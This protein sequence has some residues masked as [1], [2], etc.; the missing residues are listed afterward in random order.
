MLEGSNITESERDVDRDDE[1]TV[2]DADY[3]NAPQ[4][5]RDR[6]ASRERLVQKVMEK[7]AQGQTATPRKSSRSKSDRNLG[8]EYSS[9]SRQFDD[10]TISGAES[11]VL[12]SNTGAKSYRSGSDISNN[13][14]LLGMVEDTI[15]RIILPE[16]NALKEEKQDR[17][18]RSFESSRRPSLLEDMYNRKGLERSLSK[19]SSTPNISSKPRVVLNR[20]GEDPG[21]ILSRGDSERKKTRKSSR[22]S[23]SDE[24]PSSRHSSGRTSSRGYDDGDT[25]RAKSSKSST[26]LRDAAAAGMAGGLLTGAALK[27]HELRSKSP[28]QRKRRSKS[29]GSRSKSSLVEDESSLKKDVPPLPLVGGINESV[30]TRASIKSDATETPYTQTQ[31]PIREVSR[32]SL[33]ET[34]SP[35]DVATPPRTP[36]SRGIGMSQ[37][38]QSI[39]SP[40][41]PYGGLSTGERKAA[42]A[43]AGIGGAAAA[44]GA[45]EIYD[46]HVDADGYGSSSPITYRKTS[47]PA[48]SV[49]SLKQTFEEESLKPKELRPRSAASRSSAGRDKNASRTSLRSGTG[50]PST[51][52][53]RSRQQSSR[54]I[55]EDYATPAEEFVREG[56]P[57]TPTYGE[58][59]DEWWDRQHRVNDEYRNSLDADD[60]N[61]DSFAATTN[62]DSYQT[63]PYP[64]DEKRFTFYSEDGQEEDRSIDDLQREQDVRGLGAVPRYVHS[65]H[66]A[67]SAVASLIIEPSNVS[68]SKS[69]VSGQGSPAG[70]AS[71]SF[72]ARL[73][74]LGK[75][76]PPLYQGSTLSQTMPSQD[77]W[78]AIKGRARDISGSRDNIAESPVKSARGERSLEPIMTA[79]SIPLASDPMPEIGHFDDTKSEVSTN[80]SIIRGP[81]GGDATGKETWPYTPEPETQ[82]QRGVAEKDRQSLDIGMGKGAALAGAAA[83]GAAALAGAHALRQPTVEDDDEEDRLT[84]DIGRRSGQGVREATPSSPA[85]FRDEGYVT[86]AQTRSAGALT[87]EGDQKQY[88]KRDVDDFNRAM[89]AYAGDKED[90]F[91]GATDHSRNVSGNS[92]G[93]ASPLYDSAT[94]KGIDGIQSKDIVALMDHLTVRDAQ[95]NAR[96]TEILVTLVRSAAEMRQSFDEIKRFIVEQDRMIMQNADRSVDNTVQKALS[97]PRPQP[98]SSP[99]TPREQSQE[100]I[101]TKRK[102]VLRRALKGLTGS[103]SANDLGKVEGMLM[104]ILD[105]VEDLKHQGGPQRE[106]FGSPYT[107]GSLDTYERLRNAPDS[108]YE[109]EG[110]AGTSSTPSHSGHLSLTPRGEKQQFHSGYDGRRGSVNRVS[111]VLEGDEDDGDLEPHESHI[112]DHQFE[113]NEGFSTPTQETQRGFSPSR[114]PTQN[115]AMYN[116]LQPEEI[117]PRSTD[118]QRKHKS[119]NS[120]VFGVP[121][122]SRWSKTTSSSAAPDPAALDSPNMRNQRPMSDASR[123]GSGLGEYDDDGYEL[124]DDDR[125]RSTQSLA[126]EKEVMET[127]SMRSQ[128]S[129][130]SRTSSPLIPSEASYNQQD[131]YEQ[132]G[133][134]SPIQED[135]DYE[136]DD[137]K[138]QAHRN[139]LLLQHPQPR[140]GTTG[141][142]QNTLETQA[143]TYEGPTGTNSDVSLRSVSDFDPA[144]WGSSGTAGLAKHRL[145]Q[146]EPLSPSYMSSPAAYS[147]NRYSRDDD[148]LIPQ[149]PPIPPKIRYE[150]PEPEPEEEWEPTYSNSGFS[151]GGYYSSPFGSGHLLEPIEEV[152][153]SLE[154]DSGHVSF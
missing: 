149:K 62:R 45:K 16:I 57:G 82:A 74:E 88:S 95:R 102:G 25:I 69:K 113:R 50:S 85:M 1:V 136:L 42:L 2:K 73:R 76:S 117:T 22:G 72:S 107:N 58:S 91:T 121:K 26:K 52:I 39:E 83:A 53:A 104:R 17:N 150:E 145:S 68:S 103:K 89:D 111:T 3:L 105:N 6:S 146:L 128:A 40:K 70:K 27:S 24:R 132:A 48:Q 13:P 38:N 54:S 152:R 18:L 32:G 9:R 47:S 5:S 19:S 66:G 127:R 96:D 35:F 108:G 23:Y 43:A 37:T 60:N 144:T 79:T 129:K 94:G 75:D 81:L 65:P 8:V 86:D 67:E 64:Q 153:Y 116:G 130:V 125:L 133:E 4:G 90:P 28:D 80:P 33:R 139:S 97:G 141:R 143:H 140:Q 114:T 51:K 31:T 84:P 41:S 142:H 98:S 92:H 126:R 147:G 20:E 34:V 101:Q 135:L 7:V 46:H 63:N 15:R 137:P 115:G 131:D 151:R 100:E 134:P 110:H 71:N 78:Q 118:K 29:R 36:G 10:E 154:T 124:Q 77:R 93:M 87:P 119:N 11:S 30:L 44:I 138:Y 12:S 106:A 59:V 55:G 99:R 123:S 122:T 120:S 49:S 112:L 61:R 21:T 14:R 148:S 56:T 109:P